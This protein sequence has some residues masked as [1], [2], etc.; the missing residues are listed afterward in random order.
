MNF[1]GQEAYISNDVYDWQG[2]KVDYEGRIHGDILTEEEMQK[3]MELQSSRL[4]TIQRYKE[5]E[6]EER[7]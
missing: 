7:R 4:A 1:K 3:E 6:E 2:N 5:Q